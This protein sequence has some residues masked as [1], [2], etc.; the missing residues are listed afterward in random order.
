MKLIFSTLFILITAL[1][2]KAQL[3]ET[4]ISTGILGLPNYQEEIKGYDIQETNDGNYV[5]AAK[6]KSGMAGNLTYRPMLAKLDGSTGVEFWTKEYPVF[7]GG[8]LQEV[9]LVE[10]P[11]GNLLMA[12]I[13]YNEIFLIE[14]DAMA[15]SSEQG[16][17]SCSNF[18]RQDGSYFKSG[19]GLANYKQLVF[20]NCLRSLHFF[21]C[22]F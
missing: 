14:T 17:W 5:F 6:I 15:R 20:N 8:S 12:G 2:L 1:S 10:K 4:E 11:N 7:S 16:N 9:S 22:N 21:S 13:N 3:W 18:L 19:C